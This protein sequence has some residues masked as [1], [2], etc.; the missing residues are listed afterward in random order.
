MSILDIQ[1]RLRRLGNIRPGTKGPKGNPIKLETWR[2]TSTDKTLLQSA[3]DQYGGTV[4]PWG[5]QWELITGTDSLPVEVAPQNLT[6]NQ[7]LELWS[8]GGL[9]RRCDGT[10]CMV[11]NGDG[12]VEKPC[13][14]AET[15]KD[16]CAPHTGVDFFLYELPGIGVWRLSSTGWNA[17]S[18]MGAL[19]P[20]LQGSAARV[21]LRLEKRTVKREGQPTHNFVVPVIDAP[22]SLGMLRAAAGDRMSLVAP[23]SPASLG[24][25]GVDMVGA[26]S[27]SGLMVGEG[28]E[29]ESQEG[30]VPVQSGVDALE[31]VPL[32]PKDDTVVED[33]KPAWLKELVGR[34]VVDR[35]EAEAQVRAHLEGMPDDG[36]TMDTNEVWVRRLFRLME[37]WW[38]TPTE[39]PNAGK[40]AL[41]LALSKRYRISHL[42]QL[43]A[44]ELRSFTELSAEKAKEKIDE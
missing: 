28:P 36:A 24:M 43:K 15:G 5:D 34:V 29:A 26:S 14:C 4:Q 7:H 10:T 37:P 22:V 2:L 30:S 41:H 13:I 20:M 33:G 8:A 38:K 35:S 25:G 42:G 1:A 6:A 3:A 11:P 40:D 18:E 21:V 27:D 31:L 17:A 19:V 9:Q 32:I 39:G 12:M 23:S 44:K 16:E